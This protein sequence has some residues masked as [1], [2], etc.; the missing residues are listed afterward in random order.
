MANI[1]TLAQGGNDIAAGGAA[2]QGLRFL[3]A[4]FDIA[5]FTAAGGVT[6]DTATIWNVPA[7]TYFEL[8]QAEV[9]TAFSLGAGARIDIGDESDDD[10]F[11]TNATTLTAGTNLT[12]AKETFTGGKVISAADSLRVKVTGGTI[13]S[14]V[15]RLVA[16]VGDAQRKAIATSP[17]PDASS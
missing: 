17:I 4:E 16:V 10:E 6:T 11:V 13:A 5:D 8:I 2:K 9:V 12:L 14:G 15:L 1:T 3:K 7:D